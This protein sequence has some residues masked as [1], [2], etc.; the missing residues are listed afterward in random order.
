MRALALH[1]RLFMFASASPDNIKQWKC[2]NGEFMQVSFTW[3]VSREHKY[4]FRICRATTRSSTLW[5][6]TRTE[7]LCRAA[8]TAPCASGTGDPASASRFLFY[9]SSISR[10]DLNQIHLAYLRKPKYS[11]QCLDD[12]TPNVS[13]FYRKIAIC[14]SS[15]PL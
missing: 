13:T 10:Q 3:H 15:L 9:F 5:S 11:E 2:P 6:A 4:S 8:T 7:S 12:C 1:P 14:I